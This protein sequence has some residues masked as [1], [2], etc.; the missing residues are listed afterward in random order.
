MNEVIRLR[1][2]ALLIPRTR[3][4][5]FCAIFAA[6]AAL[7]P[8]MLNLDGDLPRHLLTGRY[9][10]Q[11]GSVPT[12]EPFAYPY[13]GKT[14]VSHE[15]LADVAFQLTYQSLGL[16]GL[17]AL[18]G[19][20]LASTFSLLYWH[21]SSRLELRLPVL[22]LFV[23]GAAATSLNWAVRPHLI[24]M[25]LLAIWLI[26]ADMLNRGKSVPVWVFFAY[27][28]LW[29][30]LHGEFIAGVLVLMAYTAGWTIEYFFD[31]SGADRRTGGRL[32]LALFLSA[33]ASMINPAGIRPW[34]T[35]FGFVNNRYLMSRMAEANPPDFSRPE[36]LVLLSLLGFSIILPAISPSRLKPGQAFLLAGFSAMSLLAARNIHLYGVV[37]PFVLSESLRGWNF[38]KSLSGPEHT[39]ARVE[40]NSKS[41]V[42]PVLVTFALG[43][44]ILFGAPRTA[45]VFSPTVFPTHAVAWLES[46]PQQG[47][48]FND[49]NWGGYIALHL[50]PDHRVFADSMADT[51]GELTRHYEIVIT[52]AD[53]WEA[54]LEHYEVSWVIV[55]NDSPLAVALA[56]DPAWKIH[57]ADSTAVVMSRESIP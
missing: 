27:M 8:L 30:N 35:I 24:S 2:T 3:D 20:L 40:G 48:M 42:W 32:W 46:H 26:L 28:A 41:I 17:I 33:L 23:W 7:G 14:Y 56:A 1:L 37:A 39:L 9:I 25:L 21:T 45:Y 31:R 54:L 53:G 51:S 57:Y 34:F 38:P 19:I 12:T 4:V 10:L 11:T 18:S 5:L 6:V 50:W 52:R 43:G 13:A 15:W 55:P 44:I 36:F 22:A 47:R 49:L 16:P 29:S